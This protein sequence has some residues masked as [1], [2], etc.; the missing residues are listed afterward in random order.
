V[1]GLALLALATIC[2]P[3]IV[4]AE[5]TAKAAKTGTM[6]ITAHSFKSDDGQAMVAVYRGGEHWL[7]PSKAYQKLIVPIKDGK[8]TVTLKD[9]PYDTYA[10][11]VVHDTNKNGKMDMRYLP[12][13]KPEEGGGVSNNYVRSGKPEYSKAKFEFAKALMSIRITMI[14]S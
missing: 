6:V 3:A 10:V 7:D 12:Y 2:A 4:G 8:I 13:P 1:V 5:E 9:V 14:Y 11:S